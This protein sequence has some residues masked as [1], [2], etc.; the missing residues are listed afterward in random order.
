MAECALTRS[1]PR[2]ISR[3]EFSTGPPE[4][5][6]AE[7]RCRSICARN[8]VSEQAFPGGPVY[9]LK[10]RRSPASLRSAAA[11]ARGAALAA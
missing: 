1:R 5:E 7:S 3:A 10:S 8:E 4:T 6:S 2:G 11:H 9:F